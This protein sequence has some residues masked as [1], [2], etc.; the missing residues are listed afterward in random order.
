[1][2][3]VKKKENGVICA[4]ELN[5]WNSKRVAFIL[6][7]IIVIIIALVML[8]PIIWMCLSAFK[9]TQEF[10]QKPATIFPKHIEFG[11]I[12]R[13]WKN[14]QMSS[15]IL[16]TVIMTGGCIISNLVVSC[17]AGFS[18]SK[19]KPAGWK[20]ISKI[21]F[22]MLLIPMSMSTVPLFM[23]FIDLPI[24][25]ISLKNTFVP[26]WIMSGINVFNILMVK[27]FFDGIPESYVEAAQIDGASNM[28]I[29]TRIMLPLSLPLLATLAIFAFTVNW[30]QFFWPMLVIDKQELMPV[31][32]KIYL[33]KKDLPI[34][35]YMMALLLAVLPIM[36]VFILLQKNIMK[37]VAIG[38]VKG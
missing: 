5:T 26:M 11:K 27:S 9:D 33:L 34:D 25:H 22:I 37:G 4:S 29:F 1:M 18:L 7:N 21:I 3:K 23:F 17:L 31:G 32:L 20:I 10:L 8:I 30:G 12:A 15:A 28:K 19:L 35:E 16:N 2:L 36:I 24:I 13:V 14:T 38:G 6:I